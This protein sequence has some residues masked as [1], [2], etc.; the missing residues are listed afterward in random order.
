MVNKLIANILGNGMR[1]LILK[2]IGISVRIA[3][4][5]VNNIE[6]KN[7]QSKSTRKTKRVEWHFETM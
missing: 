4:S 5:F 6:P 3:T 1:L 7:E 2:K